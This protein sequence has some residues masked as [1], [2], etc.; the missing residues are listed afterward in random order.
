MDSRK[1]SKKSRAAKLEKLTAHM[2]A[3]DPAGYLY[4][5]TGWFAYSEEQ[6]TWSQDKMEGCYCYLLGALA[7]AEIDT[8]KP[9]TN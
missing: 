8:E 2:A 7:L 3:H 4:D 6:G 5:I 1:L 9:P